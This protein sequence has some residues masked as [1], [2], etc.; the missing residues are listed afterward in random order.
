MIHPSYNELFDAI[1]K[2]AEN[3]EPIGSSRY[4]ICVATAKR[5]RQIIDKSEP[6]ATA[7]CNKPLSVAIE[8]IYQ[9]K[10]KIL[11][12]TEEETEEPS[13]PLYAEEV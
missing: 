7:S 10:V 5:A 9:G 1:N 3:A 4:S 13:A 6:L 8:E 2:D 11:S 12:T